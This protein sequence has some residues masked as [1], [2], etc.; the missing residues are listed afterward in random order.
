MLK[1]IGS[2][3]SKFDEAFV[4]H[5]FKES[6]LYVNAL[7]GKVD[8]RLNSDLYRFDIGPSFIEKL[9]IEDIMMGFH[10]WGCV[11]V[12]LFPLGLWPSSLPK[13]MQN[14]TNRYVS[15]ELK[16]FGQN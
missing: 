11:L 13:Q 9:L 10:L 6:N 5:A 1:K 2:P 8:C 12:V 16:K 15:D 4:K 14:L 7:L 3:L